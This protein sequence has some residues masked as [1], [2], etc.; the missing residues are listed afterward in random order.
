[1]TTTT[2]TTT[3]QLMVP[4]IPANAQWPYSGVTVAGGQEYGNATNQLW[5]PHALFMDDDQTMIIADT[6]NHRIMQWKMNDTNGEV[7]AG[8][9]GRGNRLDQL[10]LPTDVLIDK[11]T[12]SLVICDRENRRVV[13]WPRR[14]GTTQGEIV[15]DNIYC[16]GLAMDNQRYLYISDTTKNEVRRY[17]IGDKHGTIVAGGNGA[18]AGFNQLHGPICVFVDQQEAIYV[19]EH[20][21]YRVMKWNKGAKEGIVVA[22]GQGFGDGMKQLSN[23]RG[24]QDL[25]HTEQ[26]D[27][28][29]LLK[30][31]NNY[32]MPQMSSWSVHSLCQKANDSCES[33]SSQ[34]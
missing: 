1:M 28:S 18:G 19:S 32:W 7:V 30:Y 12:D 8:G 17:E 21:N 25:L 10:N 24:L 15:I 5:S 20:Y 14:S 16:Q 4:N 34:N 27:L 6:F 29:N 23:P 9:R 13:R 3:Q 33:M 31:F 11:E 2:K 26:D 22:G